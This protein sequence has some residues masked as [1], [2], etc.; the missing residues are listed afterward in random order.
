MNYEVSIKVKSNEENAF[1][2]VASELNKWWGKIDNQVSKEGDEFSISFGNTNWR[3][4]ITEFSQHEKIT[5]KCINAEHFV[6]GLTNIKEE[7]LNTELFWNFKKNNDYVEISLEHRGLTPALNCYD[8]CES[9][10]NFFISTSLKN[11]LESGH[12]NPRFEQ[13]S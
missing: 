5:W 10:W 11:Y 8:I 6:E 1:N 9:G 4:L 2:A 3:F 13:S 7:W 12:G